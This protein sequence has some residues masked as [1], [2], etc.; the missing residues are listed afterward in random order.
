MSQEFVYTVDGYTYVLRPIFKLSSA[1]FIRVIG[2]EMYGRRN[3][4]YYGYWSRENIPMKLVHTLENYCRMAY[5]QG[6]Y[7]RD[8]DGKMRSIMD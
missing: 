3:M 8:E 5:A 7:Q 2:C 6:R 1:K 4:K